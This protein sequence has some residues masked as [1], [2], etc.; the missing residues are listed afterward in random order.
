RD[1]IRGRSGRARG[2]GLRAALRCGL[3][4]PRH[5]RR[6]RGVAFS[7]AHRVGRDART[8]SEVAARNHSVDRGD[9]A[10]A[11]S[12]AEIQADIALTRRHIETQ[13]DRF[14]QRLTRR[15]RTLIVLGGAFVA[16]LLLSQLPVLR[17]LRLTAGGARAGATVAGTVAALGG[18]AA[19][20]ERLREK[21][22]GLRAA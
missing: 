20:M 8:K 7:H 22:R 11:R 16:G 12:T 21:P 5:R 13:L 6:R 2:R 10:M 15:G 17:L 9:V 14:E 19:T 1:R 3:A 18:M 4:A